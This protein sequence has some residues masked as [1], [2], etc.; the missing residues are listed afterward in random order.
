MNKTIQGLSNSCP[1][2]SKKEI[3]TFW[4]QAKGMTKSSPGYWGIVASITKRRTEKLNAERMKQDEQ[5]WLEEAQRRSE[6]DW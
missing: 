5:Q 4:N 6:G 3:E 1:H 2:V